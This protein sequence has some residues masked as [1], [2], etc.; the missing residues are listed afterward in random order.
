MR[1]QGG[2]LIFDFRYSPGR[3]PLSRWLVPALALGFSLA[4]AGFSRGFLELDELA[5]FLFARAVWHDWR[6]LVNVWARLGPTGL[7]ALAAPLG[8]V[9]PRLVAVAVTAL[10]ASGTSLLLQHFLRDAHGGF[11]RRH[12]TACAWLL[13]FA[14]PC[15]LLNSFTVMTEMPLACAWVWALVALVRW[16]R[17]ALAGLLLGMGGLMR[18][19]GWLAIAA[20]P[21]ILACFSG[22][23][24][25]PRPARRLGSL[26][27]SM[28][29]AVLPAGVWYLLWMAAWHDPQRF[30]GTWPWP[31]ASQYGRNGLLFVLSSLVV[32]A[33]WMW[34][35][36]LLGAWTC[37]KNRVQSPGAWYLVALPA[38]A[39]FLFHATA[40]TWGLFGSLSLPR[41]FV[42]VAPQ[43]AIL[44]V[45]GLVRL[46]P[47][48][49]RALPMVVVALALLPL[50]A[51]TALGYLPMRPTVEQQRLDIAVQ[52]V[53][54]RGADTSRL[55]VGHVYVLFQLRLDPDCP[56]HVRAISRDDIAEAPAGTLL[57][58]DT[59]T[60]VYDGGPTAEELRQ[61]DYRED[62]LI[63]ARVDGVVERFE[64]LTFKAAGAGAARVRLWV[65]E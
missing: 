45:L 65:K 17:G 44:A 24:A 48:A 51:L 19:E 56:A 53:R 12:A 25:G 36:V 1:A 16:R 28:F 13:L 10:T 59:E 22:L 34:A 11:F 5:H 55:I 61:W 42:A 3:A 49:G 23:F 37:W 38:A 6:Q 62:P 20:W 46:E 4:M 47:R 15:F 54:D 7:Y 60:W 9:G 64:P 18:P 2:F 30:T 29:L 26:L 52:A 32:L 31:A 43:I 58:A 8:I 63:T 57:I 27:L 39:F 21:V 41:Y 35:P 40:G 33:V 14:Q 50:A